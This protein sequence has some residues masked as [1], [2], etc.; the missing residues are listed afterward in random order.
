M[1]AAGSSMARPGP[2]CCHNQGSEP[3]HMPKRP[4]STEGM[5]AESRTALRDAQPW[6]SPVWLAMITL[7][8]G[9]WRWRSAEGPKSK[10]RY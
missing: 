5:E 6:M 7:A 2:V 10:L 1:P 8:K 3:D 9:L 4:R